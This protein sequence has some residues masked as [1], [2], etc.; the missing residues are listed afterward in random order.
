MLLF[1]PNL[2]PAYSLLLLPVAQWW[3]LYL[4][5]P[6]QLKK[7]QTL[8]LIEIWGKEL[9][10]NR[11]LDALYYLVI[12]ACSRKGLDGTGINVRLESWGNVLIEV[13]YVIGL[14]QICKSFSSCL[15]WPTGVMLW[16][17]ELLIELTWKQLW[18]SGLCLY[19]FLSLKNEG[20]QGDRDASVCLCLTAGCAS[21]LRNMIITP[22]LII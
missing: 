1:K 13:A 6:Y 14:R 20:L 3:L 4:P 17:P 22:G 19:L 16:G 8:F 21:G 5:E 7:K 15:G 10:G 2:W 18:F 9:S 11:Y 12:I